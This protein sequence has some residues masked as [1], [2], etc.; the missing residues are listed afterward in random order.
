MML[1]GHLKNLWVNSGPLASA[2]I[3]FPG[4]EC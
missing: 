4:E 2:E 3:A 1:G